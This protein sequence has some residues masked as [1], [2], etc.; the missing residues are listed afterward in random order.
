M[1]EH[2]KTVPTLETERLLL[3]GITLEDTKC[4]V[5]WRSDGDVYRYFQAP[6]R[7]SAEEHT[8]WYAK[9]Y[10]TDDARLQW[11]GFR[12]DT[13]EKIGV[14]GVKRENNRWQEAEI[15]YLLSKQSKGCGFG[16][17]AVRRIMEWCEE[18]GIT[19][20]K[21]TVHEENRDSIRFIGRMGFSRNGQA[22]RFI[23]YE[24]RFLSQGGYWTC[25][26]G[27]DISGTD[28]RRAAS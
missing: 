20:L 9:E 15:S 27:I 17:E 23:I 12:K 13:G 28:I 8:A 5:F 18:N 6:H 3:R 25:R 26:I 4:I 2:E 24:K 1:G 19:R 21:A 16:S 14:F 10:V 7:L 11:I 22:G